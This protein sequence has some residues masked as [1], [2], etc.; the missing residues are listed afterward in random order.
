MAL[1]PVT[2]TGA[3]KDNIKEGFTKVN[4]I[5]DDLAATTSGLGASCIGI[6][7]T[8][9]N[10]TAANVETALAEVYTDHAAALVISAAFDVNSAT[11][12]G[13]TWGYKGGLLRNDTTLVTVAAGTVSL[14]DDTT[15]YIEIDSAGTI[16]VVASAFTSGRVPIRTVVTASGV[17]GTSTDKRAWFSVGTAGLG[18][19]LYF[20]AMNV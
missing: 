20:F 14:T 10:Y 9:G 6:L 4:D 1:T 2:M 12:T 5:I 17:Q 8:A 16:Y 19:Q 7:D 13:L 18:P 11:T 15:N 3:S